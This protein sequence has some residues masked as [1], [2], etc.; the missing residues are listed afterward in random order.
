M[1]RPRRHAGAVDVRRAVSSLRGRQLDA[2][3]N[4]S[5]RTATE[6]GLAPSP[7]SERARSRAMRLSRDPS[8]ARERAPTGRLLAG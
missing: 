3:S 4:V 8:F 5:G 6:D 2:R 7:A 1:R